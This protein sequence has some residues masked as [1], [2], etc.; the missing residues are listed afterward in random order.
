M[1]TI[2][3]PSEPLEAPIQPRNKH[4]FTPKKR[5]KVSFLVN[6]PLFI[7]SFFVSAALWLE[8]RRAPVSPAAVCGGNEQENKHVVL[9]NVN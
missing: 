8:A 2:L 7:L 5:G 4:S 1:V 9:N 3:M 6:L